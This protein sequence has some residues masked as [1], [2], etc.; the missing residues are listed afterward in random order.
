[1]S[2]KK[3]QQLPA[4]QEQRLAVEQ[5]AVK[6]ENLPKT[7]ID[8]TKNGAFYIERVEKSSKET[9]LKIYGKAV[10]QDEIQNACVF[11]SNPAFNL[12]IEG[13]EPK[14]R[15]H[16]LHQ[17]DPVGNWETILDEFTTQGYILFDVTKSGTYPRKNN[18]LLK[19]DEY[20]KQ[21]RTAC[22]RVTSN[23]KSAVMKLKKLDEIVT[24][25]LPQI[26]G[27]AD[28]ELVVTGW[29]KYK[30]T[31]DEYA[32]RTDERN[33]IT[34]EI[35]K[36]QKTLSNTLKSLQDANIDKTQLLELVQNLLNE[37]GGAE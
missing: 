25:T 15:T 22:V 31:L 11:Y 23:S 28:Y 6:L 26:A 29:Q 2:T 14:K 17:N 33:A 34:N 5:L 3:E 1:M 12:K 24:T 36:Q 4:T 9:I 32:T 8:S 27:A 37:N 18:Q 30:K 10:Y 13:Y 16:E 35:S 7:E 20:E 19:Q 21:I